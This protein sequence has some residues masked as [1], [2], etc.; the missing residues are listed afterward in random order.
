M[1]LGQ[2][3]EA[4]GIGRTATLGCPL[5][6]CDSNYAGSQIRDGDIAEDSQEWLSYNS[7]FVVPGARE[8]YDSS[9]CEKSRDPMKTSTKVRR[10]IYL[11]AIVFVFGGLS[12]SAQ[13]E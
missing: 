12:L 6:C 11:A 2:I 10:V 7:N 1:R 4:I 3:V 9:A 5:L 13:Q 8:A